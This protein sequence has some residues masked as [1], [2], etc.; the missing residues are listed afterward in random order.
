M[1]IPIR[2]I[3]QHH[4]IIKWCNNSIFRLVSIPYQISGYHNLKC[5]KHSDSRNDAKSLFNALQSVRIRKGSNAENAIDTNVTSKDYCILYRF[6]YIRVGGVVNKLKKHFTVVTV[7]GVPA[8]ALL[9]FMG[10]ISTDTMT[11]FIAVGM[12]CISVVNRSKLWKFR[13]FPI[14]YKKKILSFL[15]PHYLPIM[16]M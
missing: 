13:P 7:A 6:P 14:Y 5:K 15:R 16:Y 10:A 1:A 8:S 4:Y 12:I 2:G 3:I 9:Q 11:V